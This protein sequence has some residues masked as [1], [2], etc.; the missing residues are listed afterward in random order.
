MGL[1]DWLSGESIECP[2]CGGRSRMICKAGERDTDDE[3][4]S[5]RMAS[6]MGKGFGRGMGNMIQGGGN[7]YAMLGTLGV[8]A[9]I[10]AYKQY[11]ITN[12]PKWRCN[13]CGHTFRK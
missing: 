6:S 13:K 1:F 9:G 11:V 8:K 7:P 2:Q 10:E 5:M 3:R 4:S 12:K